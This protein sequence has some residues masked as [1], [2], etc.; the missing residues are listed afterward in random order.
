MSRSYI[1]TPYSDAAPAPAQHDEVGC[2]E[3][4]AHCALCGAPVLYGAR[5]REHYGVYPLSAKPNV[6]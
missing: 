1:D 6:R 3:W 5:C 4:C 2:I